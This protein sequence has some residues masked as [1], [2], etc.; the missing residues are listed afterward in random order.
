MHLGG[1]DINFEGEFAPP[2]NDANLSLNARLGCDGS[3]KGQ[4]QDTYAGG[5]SIHGE[6]TCL[7]VLGNDAYV[8]GV[9]THSNTPDQGDLT[10]EFFFLRVMDNGKNN[11]HSDPDQASPVYTTPMWSFGLAGQYFCEEEIPVELYDLNNGQAT[12][13]SR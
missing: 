9:I 5:Q 6:V 11:K 1:A 7:V 10:G 13:S 8:S 12:V 2:N 4:L 3:V